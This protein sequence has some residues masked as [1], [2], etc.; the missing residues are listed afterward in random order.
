MRTTIERIRASEVIVHAHEGYVDRPAF[1]PSIFDKASKW[2]LEIF[3]DD[4]LV[5]YGESSRGVSKTDVE[6]SARMVIG[7]PLTDF[8]WRAEPA[9]DFSDD[10]MFGH[11]TPPV[12]H[13]LYEREFGS[14]SGMAA[15]RVAL[16][17]LLA[18]RQ[19]VPLHDLFGGA[20]RHSVPTSWWMGRTDAEHA[21]RQMEIG[22]EMG[23]TGIKLKAAAE[24]DVLGIV[25]A[26]KK[27]AGDKA[28]IGIDPNQRFYRLSEAVR[29]AHQLEAF[30]NILFE[31]PFPFDVDEWRLFRQK[32]TVPLALHSGG[33]LPLALANHCCDFLNLSGGAFAFMANAHLAA[34][35]QVLC[36]HGSGLELGILDAYR[37]HLAATTRTC[38]LTGDTVGHRIRSDDLIEEALVVEDGAI[39]VPPGAGIGVTLDQQAVDKHL[40]SRFELIDK[41]L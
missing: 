22:L 16:D 23:F 30:D 5:G 39:L 35:Y 21:A 40:V 33:P 6:H 32:T 4:G 19:G 25:Q 34:R 38:M 14:S 31:D 10:D 24:D 18:K 20:C 9:P 2:L 27:V 28:S 26:I 11:R 41:D 7:K 15:V 1:G 17:D 36:W 8:P 29:I 3:T 37:L 12:P 13:R